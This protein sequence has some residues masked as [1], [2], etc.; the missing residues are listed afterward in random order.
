MPRDPK[1]FTQRRIQLVVG[2][3]LA[4][5]LYLQF[6]LTEENEVILGPRSPIV[7]AA[8]VTQDPFERLIRTDPPSRSRR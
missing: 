4:G 8:T 2:A 3:V 7:M 5:I 6:A 1:Q